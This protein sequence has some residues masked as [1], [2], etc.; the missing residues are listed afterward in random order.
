MNFSI[1]EFLKA[2]PIP[3][4]GLIL[5]TVSLGNLLFSEGFEKV[6]NAF[7]S[8]GFLIMMLIMLKIIFTFKHTLADLKNPIVA[9]VSPTFTMAWMVICA[10][11]NRLLPGS[12]IVSGIWVAAVTLHLVLMLYFIVAHIFPVK[13]TLKSIYPSWFITFV[14]IGVIPN[15]SGAFV[16]EL[17]EFFVWAALILYFILLPVIIKRV[18]DSEKM[19]DSAIPLTTILTAP[20][21]LCL[22]GYLSVFK[23][24]SL[25][26]V[27]GLLILSQLI[28][29]SILLYFRKMLKVGFYP[30]Y[31][32]FTFPLVISATAVFKVSKF[33]EGSPVATVTTWLSIFETL[34]AILVVCYVLTKYFI[35]FRAQAKALRLKHEYE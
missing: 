10:F 32:A 24:A 5:G 35:Y 16:E 13:V 9:S 23:E 17:G 21:S 22:A 1:K 27:V 29:F 8:I 33:F 7:C 15:T 31:A 14:G 2:V 11:L 34:A 3:M 20:G 28:Y 6:G 18:I 4:C 12:A 25:P 30:S 26:F 19:A